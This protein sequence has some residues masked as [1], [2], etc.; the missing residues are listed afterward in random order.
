MKKIFTIFFLLL[1][2]VSY[3]QLFENNFNL[4]A[5]NATRLNVERAT[6]YDPGPGDWQFAHAPSIA[7]FKGKFYAIF[8]NGRIGEDEGEQRIVLSESSGFTTW[9][10][11][12]PLAS[13]TA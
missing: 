13:T 3:A 2:H 12:L 10:T 11:P 6:I 9:T 5:Y 4:F 1:I 8:A 7:F